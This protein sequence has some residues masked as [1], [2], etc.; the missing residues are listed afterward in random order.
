V[1][2][3]NWSSQD[4]RL[5]DI[6]NQITQSYPTIR[7]TLAKVVRYNGIGVNLFP[8]SP[9]LLRHWQEM[10]LLFPPI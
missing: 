10:G 5:G 7:H 2:I 6:I 3:P 8:L 9:E 1:N 4:W